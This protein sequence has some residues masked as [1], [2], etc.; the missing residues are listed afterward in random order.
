MSS[1]L[2]WVKTVIFSQNTI[3]RVD[4]HWKF[5]LMFEHNFR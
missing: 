2:F 5:F 3:H 1:R 4:T